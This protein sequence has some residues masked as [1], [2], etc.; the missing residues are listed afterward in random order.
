MAQPAP[1]QPAAPQP[2]AP[3]PAS[4]S[5]DSYNLHSCAL[6]AQTAVEKLATELAHAGAPRQVTSTVTSMADAIRQIVSFTGGKAAS[7][8]APQPQQHTMSSAANALVADVAAKK[9]QGGK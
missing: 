9:A 6:K 2:A 5:S 8:P 4:G 7:Q 1:Q 3:Q